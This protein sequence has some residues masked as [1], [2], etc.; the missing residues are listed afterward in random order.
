MFG[1]AVEL[2]AVLVPVHLLKHHPVW[3]HLT[4]RAWGMTNSGLNRTS[5]KEEGWFSRLVQNQYW[6]GGISD[7]HTFHL[8][9][10]RCILYL[11][12]SIFH[13]VSSS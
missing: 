11:V 13:T 10:Y 5:P 1:E 9:Q 2:F 6:P 3:L 7:C 12:S 8:Y 4:S